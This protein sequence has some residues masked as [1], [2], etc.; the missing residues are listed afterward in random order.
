MQKQ[1][2]MTPPPFDDPAETFHVASKLSTWTSSSATGPY[3]YELANDPDALE[4]LGRAH[5]HY[6]S[7]ERYPLAPADHR[8]P[9]GDVLRRRRSVPAFGQ[10]AVAFDSFSRILRES[11]CITEAY[12]RGAPSAGALYPIDIYLCVNNVEGLPAGVYALD[13]H[14]ASLHRLSV[15]EDPRTFLQEC[16]VFQDLADNSAFHVFF[17][18]SFVRQRIK[19]GQ[20]A[21]R[22]ALIEAGHI[23]Q[24]MIMCGLEEGIASCPVG[25]FIDK[26]VDDLLCLDGVEQSVVYSV[27]FGSSQAIDGVVE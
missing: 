13:P 26:Q 2:L 22:F 11:A 12:G 25:G 9:V 24:A 18:G 8:T 17:V 7:S 23:A 4:Q 15:D 14:G 10:K 5:P 19:Y 6:V 21:Y 20:R 3:S 1:W 27:A 16:L